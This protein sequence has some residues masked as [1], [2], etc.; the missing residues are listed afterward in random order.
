[1]NVHQICCWKCRNQEFAILVMLCQMA[2][3]KIQTKIVS[4]AITENYS[5]AGNRNRCRQVLV[6]RYPNNSIIIIIVIIN[7]NIFGVA[8]VSFMYYV[9]MN[10]DLNYDD[11]NNMNN[12]IDDI[13]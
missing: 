11:N 7:I 6:N 10:N 5:L 3:I 2:R 8:A 9:S 1:M 4:V 12:N 13:E